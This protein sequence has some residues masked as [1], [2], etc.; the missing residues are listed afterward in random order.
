MVKQDELPIADEAADATMVTA[1]DE[2]HIALYLRLLDADRDG[3]SESHMARVI[4]EIERIEE[5]ERARRVVQS[6]LARAR[7]MTEHGYLDLLGK[8]GS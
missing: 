7:W 5:P 2:H 6:H 1:Y 4:F 3:A 8:R